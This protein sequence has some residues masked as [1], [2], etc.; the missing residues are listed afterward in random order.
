MSGNLD[1]WT[2][3]SWIVGNLEDWTLD[4][5][6]VGNLDDWTVGQLDGWKSGCLGIG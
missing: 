4:C 1:D 5:W 6:V 2:L 3:D